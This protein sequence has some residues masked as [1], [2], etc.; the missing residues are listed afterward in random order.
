MTWLPKESV[1]KT[2]PKNVTTVGHGKSWCIIGCSEVFIE[3][4]KELDA[5]AA[6]WPDYKSH[7]TI[8]FLIG[9]S[10]TGLIS[11]FSDTYVGRASDKFIYT[12][13]GLFDSLEDSYDE[14]MADGAS[15]I[16]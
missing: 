9:I 7:N 13:G 2:M 3:R 10:P 15:Q 16:T 4:P 1:M 12:D 5:Q 6:S 11:F 8:N 14:V